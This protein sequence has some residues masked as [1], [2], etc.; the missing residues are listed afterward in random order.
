ML[1]YRDS[2]IARIALIV[3]FILFLG[4]GYFE[5]QAVLFGPRIITPSSVIV[6]H[7]AFTT[8]QGQA[9]NI[10]EL[11]M[12][13]A[14]VSVT[15]DGTFNEPYVLAPGENRIILDAKDKYGRARRHIIE[16]VYVPEESSAKTA[17]TT[18]PYSTTTTAVPLVK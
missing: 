3:F 16:I 10:A 12:N 17:S 4:Y 11:R 15:E 7:E 14:A 6:A 8:I 2:R 13:G 18:L 9:Q 5:A 1:P